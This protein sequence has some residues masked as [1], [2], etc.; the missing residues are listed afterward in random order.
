[1]FNTSAGITDTI[2]IL[3]YI[4]YLAFLYHTHKEGRKKKTRSLGRVISYDS[5]ALRVSLP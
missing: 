2:Y 1:M 3:I 4:E 5:M